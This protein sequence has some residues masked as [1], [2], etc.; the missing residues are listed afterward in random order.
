MVT[1]IFTPGCPLLSPVAMATKFETIGYDSACV[2]IF[3]QY[4]C[5]H[6]GVF[7]DGPSNAANHIYPRPTA[8][9]MAT[10][11]GTKLAITRLA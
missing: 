2:K 1:F 5:A 7:D 6:W 10:K 9:A 11:F 8:V 4:F 3:L